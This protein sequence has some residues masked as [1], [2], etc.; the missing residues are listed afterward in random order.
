MFTTERKQNLISLIR[1]WMMDIHNR[2]SSIA[3]GLTSEHRQFIELLEGDDGSITFEQWK[4][5]AKSL[6]HLHAMARNDAYDG[7]VCDT[8][9]DADGNPLDDG[10]VEVSREERDVRRL[11]YIYRDEYGE[12]EEE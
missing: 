10:W 12:G 5:A 7:H 1:G 2:N 9:L 6:M 8:A 3:W 4:K 11:L